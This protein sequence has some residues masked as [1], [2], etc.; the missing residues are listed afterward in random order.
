MLD[1]TV[2][3]LPIFMFPMNDSSPANMI[4]CTL[5]LHMPFRIDIGETN[6]QYLLN[7]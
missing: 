6:I 5:D 1:I 2:S 4:L 7:E 3:L